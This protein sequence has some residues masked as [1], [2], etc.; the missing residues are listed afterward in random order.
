MEPVIR[1]AEDRD[2]HVVL[3]IAR[4]LVQAADTYAF[5]AGMSDD[6]LWQYWHPDFGGQG[7]VAEVDGEV[8]GVFVIKRNH[9]GPASHIANASYVVRNNQRGKGIGAAMGKASLR[10]ARDMGFR[11]MQFNIVLVTNQPAIRVW[12]RLGFQIMGTIPDGFRSPDGRYVDFH[13]MHRRL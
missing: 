9:Q 10:L 5:D 3:A 7:F 4:D 8:V 6:A 1:Q 13:I 11:A 2:R 12:Q